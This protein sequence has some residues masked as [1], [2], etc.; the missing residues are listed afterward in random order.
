MNNIIEICNPEKKWT[1]EEANQILPLLLKLSAQCDTEVDKLLKNQ[2]ALM[3]MGA[4]KA[5]IDKID[6]MVQQELLKWGSKVT[7]LGIKYHYGY[8]LFD[9]GSGFWS[10]QKPEPEVKYFIEYTSPVND[11]KL[12]VHEQKGT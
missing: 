4:A 5:Q 2:R 9:N 1:L 7:K 11:R 10:W 3:K 8:H 12:V 6:K